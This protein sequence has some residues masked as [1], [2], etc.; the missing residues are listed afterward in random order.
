MEMYLILSTLTGALA[1]AF[2]FYLS[3]GI[4]SAE[5]G[6]ARMK[7]IAGYIHEGAMAFLYKGVSAAMVGV[8]MG[9]ENCADFG[10][11]EVP[12][13]FSHAGVVNA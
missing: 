8:G 4:S 11:W 6:N 7:E 13:G 1:L 10:V 12:N 9:V 2:A 3:A 5:P